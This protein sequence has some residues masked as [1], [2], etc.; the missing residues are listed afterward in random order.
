[1]TNWLGDTSSWSEKPDADKVELLT[2]IRPKAKAELTGPLCPLPSGQESINI[3]YKFYS[4][5]EQLLYVS[6]NP[7]MQQLKYQE[8]FKEAHSI[9]MERYE[10]A[11]ALA[12]AKSVCIEH[13]QPTNN[14]RRT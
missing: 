7:N 12:D 3:L 6:K 9:T 10:S 8:W 5:D 14:R 11:A 2:G 13:E 4:S 1:M